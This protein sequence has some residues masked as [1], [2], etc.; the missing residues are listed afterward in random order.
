MS[1]DPGRVRIALHCVNGAVSATAVSCERPDVARLLYGQTAE[2][3]VAWAPLIYSL[4]GKAQGVAARAAVAAARGQPLAAHIDA[5]VWAEASREHAWQLFVDW[6]KQLHSTPDEGFFVR[7]MRS[8]PE[9]RAELSAALAADDLPARLL[10]GAGRGPMTDLLARRARVRLKEL[11]EWLCNQP[12]TLGTVGATCLAPDCGAATVETARGPLV[13]RVTLEGDR[14]ADYL[15]V[16]PTDVHFAVN[17]DVA[18]WLDKLCGM[19]IHAAEQQ[20]K[21]V[22]LTFDPCVPWV[23]ETL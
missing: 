19:P 8:T 21:W 22:A 23:C 9:Q 4:C 16:A 20:A 2:Q 11:D 1:F 10:A 17:G 13:H 14:I 12:G 5:A 3:A 18:K 6:P 7:L 15:I